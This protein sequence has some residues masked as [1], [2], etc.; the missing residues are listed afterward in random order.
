VG[1]TLYIILWCM[2]CFPKTPEDDEDTSD[3]RTNMVVCLVCTFIILPVFLA[4][5][6]LWIFVGSWLNR[7]QRRAALR[8]AE[9][10]EEREQALVDATDVDGADAAEAGAAETD[11]GEAGG[12]TAAASPPTKGPT[13]VPPPLETASAV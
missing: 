11:G 2:P 8:V 13:D 1:F 3:L 6:P 12:A 10:E 9:A 7:L 5:S 4:L